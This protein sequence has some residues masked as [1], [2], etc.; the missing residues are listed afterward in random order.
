[1]A[2]QEAGMIAA[3]QP[4]PAAPFVPVADY[5]VIADP[6]EFAGALLKEL[7]RG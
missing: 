5:N 1:M 4:D 3:V 7:A 2:T 6:A